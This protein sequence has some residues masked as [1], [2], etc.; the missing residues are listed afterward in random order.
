MSRCLSSLRAGQQAWLGRFRGSRWGNTVWHM[1]LNVTSTNGSSRKL[2]TRQKQASLWVTKEV[3]TRQI[4]HDQ[5]R[6]IESAI[7][8][9]SQ[10]GNHD[11]SYHML[12]KLTNELSPHAARSGL[13]PAYFSDQ[14]WSAV[15]ANEAN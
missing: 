9:G 7:G 1:A 2:S 13:L 15:E 6:G 12:R 10:Y 3:H 8:L 14:F 11:C 4:L 5:T